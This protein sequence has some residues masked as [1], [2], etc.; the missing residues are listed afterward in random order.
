M[1]SDEVYLIQLQQRRTEH[2]H[3]K[4]LWQTSVVSDIRYESHIISAQNTAHQIAGFGTG[5][6]AML[7][8]IFIEVC[9]DEVEDLEDADDKLLDGLPENIVNSMDN[10][11]LTDYLEDEGADDYDEMEN[12]ED[13]GTLQVNPPF[14]LNVQMF[15]ASPVRFL[16]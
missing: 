1:L 8:R 15:T 11:L 13:G 9:T 3:L 7:S 10:V 12:S 2:L 6:Q 4:A 5:P 14:S 16:I